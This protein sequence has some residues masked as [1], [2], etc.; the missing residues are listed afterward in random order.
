MD[1]NPSEVGAVA[2]REVAYALSRAGYD[3]YVP[4]FRPHSRVDLVAHRDGRVL[5][6]QVKAARVQRGIVRFHTCSNTR[7]EPRA[8][9]GEID[10]F[11]VYAPQVDRCYLVP[12]DEAPD[13]GCHMR[14]APPR[15]NQVKG[16][17]WA[18]DYEIG[19]RAA[20]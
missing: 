15:N 17:R 2:E 7:N 9:Q 16:I 10:V 20:P 13:R 6:V 8:Y 12:I 11:G 3:V 5:R 18:A 19:V 4:F 14:L 1:A